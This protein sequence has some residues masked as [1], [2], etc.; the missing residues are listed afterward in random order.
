MAKQKVISEADILEK[1]ISLT[2]RDLTPEAA[3][4]LLAL[5]FDGATTR[6]IRKLLRQ[7]NR[8]SITADDRPALEK[9][10]RVG[11]FLD[12]VHAKARLALREPRLNEGQFGR[13]QAGDQGLRPRSAKTY[14]Y[15]RA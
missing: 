7:N 15:S 5:R 12:L 13:D 9:Y 14:L 4:G 3:R 1:V 11:Q 2:G 8:G 10:L 6:T